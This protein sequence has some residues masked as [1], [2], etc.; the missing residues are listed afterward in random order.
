MSVSIAGYVYNL[1]F[2][3]K[4]VSINSLIDTNKKE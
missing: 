3:D 2:K 1:K 4:C